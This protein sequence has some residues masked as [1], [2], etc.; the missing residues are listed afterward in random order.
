MGSPLD[1]CFV[2]SRRIAFAGIKKLSSYK[3]APWISVG[4][5]DLGQVSGATQGSS[6]GDKIRVSASENWIEPSVLSS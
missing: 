5:V 4:F 1:G 3:Q 6:A 2:R